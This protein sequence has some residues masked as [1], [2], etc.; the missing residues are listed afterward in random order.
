[1]R[2]VPLVYPEYFRRAS[3]F[4]L[5]NAKGR[6][7]FAPTSQISVQR[8]LFKDILRKP[9]VPQPQPQVTSR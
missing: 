8:Y 2:D 3:L 9:V 6:L 1:M 7:F 5:S 4:T